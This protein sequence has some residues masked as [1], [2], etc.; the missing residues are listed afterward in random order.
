MDARELAKHVYHLPEGPL[1][2]LTTDGKR[3]LT[4]EKRFVRVVQNGLVVVYP[5]TD[6]PNY[7]AGVPI[8]LHVQNIADVRPA[9]KE[10]VA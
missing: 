9:N 3:H 7:D 8:H 4:T 2:V 1:E 6:D 10:A 5:P